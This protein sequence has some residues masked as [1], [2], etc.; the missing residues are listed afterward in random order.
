MKAWLRGRGEGE[1]RVS[2]DLQV[3]GLTPE[4]AYYYPEWHWHPDEHGGVKSLLLFFDEIALLV[5]DYKRHQ[6]AN[7]DPELAGALEDANLLRIIEPEWFV[8]AEMTGMLAEAMVAIID[9][10][11]FDDLSPT[12]PFAELSMSRA[13][14]AGE[15]EVAERVVGLLSERGLAAETA[16]G[17]SIPMHPSVRSTYLVLL[18][19]L[20]RRTG[21]RRGLDLHPATNRP[22]AQQVLDRTLNLRPM[23]SRGRV[24]DFDLE[25]V[26]IDLGPVPLDEVLAYRAD[27]Q[28][29]HRRYMS[30]LRSFC[31][32]LTLIETEADRER[33]LADRR[34]ELREAAEQLRR[35]SWKSFK[36]PKNYLS[37]GLGLVGAGVSASVG[38][39][40][41]AAAGVGVAL[42]RL[43][44]DKSDGSVYS[45]LFGAQRSLG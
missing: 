23:P 32:E 11:A 8:D 6:P 22:E 19:Q 38:N 36:Q 9:A 45:Y 7:M 5:P 37:F 14:F 12:E 21:E 39:P 17:L 30:S 41:G 15:R 44:P 4:V 24:V 43:L 26:S 33:V 2:K 18:A 10:G 34:E 31:R 20:A 28:E 25:A 3:D 35:R 1:Q 42:T 29:E 40:F 13:G 16:D 27:H